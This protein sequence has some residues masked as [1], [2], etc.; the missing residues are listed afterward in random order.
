M[1]KED[2]ATMIQ[3]WKDLGFQISSKTD[4]ATDDAL[5]YIDLPEGAFDYPSFVTGYVSDKGIAEGKVKFQFAMPVPKSDE[6]AQRY[7]DCN[8]DLI[9]RTG[10][11]GFSRSA[12]DKAKPSLFDGSQPTVEK[13]LAMQQKFASWRPGIR[14]RQAAEPS[15]KKVKELKTD[16]GFRNNVKLLVESGRTS[17]TLANQLLEAQEIAPLTQEELRSYNL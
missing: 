16:E 8:L 17:L 4:K 10:I 11:L 13:H 1:T 3:S 12:D 9:I 14:E 15:A 6:E 2:R 5:V 7:Y